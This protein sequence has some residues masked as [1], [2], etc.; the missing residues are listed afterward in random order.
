MC[1][2]TGCRGK[3]TPVNTGT[4]GVIDEPQPPLFPE[5]PPSTLKILHDSEIK[6]DAALFDYDSAQIKVS[7]RAKLD[8][9][10]DYL[11]NKNTKAGVIVEGHCDER[12]SAEYNMTLG[13][14]R[15]VAA[16]TYLTG[17]GVD[18]AKIQTK[19]LGKEKPVNPGHDEA[20][21]RVN[22][23]AEFIFFEQ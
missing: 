15:A 16:R 14:R 6:V 21:W 11:K 8:K 5:R 10:A 4:N 9:A 23:R 2:A 1:F 13:E 20:A 22:R 18:G 3:K 19:S 7:E 12:G 17:L